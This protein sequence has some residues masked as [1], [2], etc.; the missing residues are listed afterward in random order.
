MSNI[1]EKTFVIIDGQ[2]IMHRAWHAL[3]P[4]T[5]KG[6]AIVNAVYGF[7]S[8]LLKII[9]DLA[10]DYLAVAFDLPV[11][12]FRHELY[13]EYKAKRVKQPQEFYDQFPIL[14]NFL[15]EARIKYLEK[16]GLEAD[17]L[18]GSLSCL[19]DKKIN[20][21]IVT[22]DQDVL[23]LINESTKVLML[24]RGISETVLLDEKEVENKYGLKPSQMIDFK[25]LRGDPSDNLPGIRGIGEKTAVGL[26]QKFKS[27]DG[28][29][30]HL[31]NL[32]K[33]EKSPIR[34]SVKKLLEEGR[35]TIELNKKLVTIKQDDIDQIKIDDFS[36]V[37]KD[38]L[39]GGLEHLGFKGL[40]K[41]ISSNE[42]AAIKPSN[43]KIESKN[44]QNSLF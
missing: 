21:I 27:V 30:K 24:K 17:D 33:T 4:L 3:P 38:Q 7:I 5:M 37:S 28:I 16:P 42:Q 29:Y 2:A 8:I 23:Q 11:P 26:L 32:K 14:K 1:K 31:D 35:S 19:G 41:R 15:N 13:K 9:K 36:F 22:G 40:I 25:I 20:K 10:P 6:G 43:E 39:L 44:K 34:D 12:T 18:I